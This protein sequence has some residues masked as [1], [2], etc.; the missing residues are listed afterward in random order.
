M[1]I[2]DVM[3]D[4]FYVIDQLFL[5]LIVYLYFDKKMQ[6]IIKLLLNMITLYQSLYIY[7]NLENNPAVYLCS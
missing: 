6:P 3:Q 7:T 2:K 1:S 5:C 4:V